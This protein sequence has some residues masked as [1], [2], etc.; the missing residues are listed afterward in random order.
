MEKQ[1]LIPAEKCLDC[2]FAKRHLFGSFI[3]VLG[4]RP[5]VIDNKVLCNYYLDGGLTDAMKLIRKISQKAAKIK[6]KE[7]E[8]KNEKNQKGTRA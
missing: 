4:L 1:V 5:V 6:A 3:C 8:K 2:H 7:N